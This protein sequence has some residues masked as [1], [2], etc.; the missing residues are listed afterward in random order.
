MPVENK[1]KTVNFVFGRKLASLRRQ[2]DLSQS[3]LANRVGLSR[4]TIANLEGGKQNVQLSQVFV[5]AKALDAAPAE[6]IPSVRELEA[7]GVTAD[8]DLFLMMVRDQLSRVH[9]GTR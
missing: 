8:A 4:V 1:A 9:E 6:L 7:S 5:L 3:E 2:R